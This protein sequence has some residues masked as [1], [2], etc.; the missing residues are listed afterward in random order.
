MIIVKLRTSFYE[1]SSIIIILINFLANN[2][3]LV[4]KKKKKKPR[5]CNIFVNYC[6]IKSKV[7]TIKVLRSMYNFQR[8]HYSVPTQCN[9]KAGTYLYIVINHFLNIFHMIRE[10][11]YNNSTSQKLFTYIFNDRRS[12]YEIKCFNRVDFVNSYVHAGRAI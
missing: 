1:T 9:N 7:S 8:L 10:S 2:Y 3:T 6:I 12:L 5:S 11:R 4:V